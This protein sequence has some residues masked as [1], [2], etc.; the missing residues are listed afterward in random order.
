MSRFI[1]EIPEELIELKGIGS[2][3]LA[4]MNF[5]KRGDRRGIGSH[6]VSHGTASRSYLDDLGFDAEDISFGDTPTRSSFGGGGGIGS[7][8]KKKER[9]SF[10]P[11]DRIEH[12]TFGRGTIIAV[13]GD[14][15]SVEFDTIAGSKNLMVGYA[16]ISKIQ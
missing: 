10:A 11:G 15:I 14:S 9:E 5:D 7:F 2:R 6:G 1:D 12:K 13:K 16:P 4:G 3:G 8:A